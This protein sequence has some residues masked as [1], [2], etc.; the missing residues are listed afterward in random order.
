[1]R[2]KKH[3]NHHHPVPFLLAGK[4]TALGRCFTRPLTSYIG[5]RRVSL[6]YKPLNISPSPFTLILLVSVTVNVVRAAHWI[7]WSC[8]DPPNSTPIPTTSTGSLLAVPGAVKTMGQITGG[9]SVDSIRFIFARA[10]K[11]LGQESPPM[12]VYDEASAATTCSTEIFGK[13]SH[14]RTVSSRGS[15][16][17]DWYGWIPRFDLRDEPI[18]SVHC[19]GNLMTGNCPD[20]PGVGGSTRPA[21]I[22]GRL[23]TTWN[24]RSDIRGSTRRLTDELDNDNSEMDSVL[25]GLSMVNTDEGTASNDTRMAPTRHNALLSPRRK[26]VETGESIEVETRDRRR[27]PSK[28]PAEPQD[29]NAKEQ[30]LA[31]STPEYSEWRDGPCRQRDAMSTMSVCAPLDKV[32][33]DNVRHRVTHSRHRHLYYPVESGARLMFYQTHISS[34]LTKYISFPPSV[35]VRISAL[36][37]FNRTNSGAMAHGIGELEETKN[38]SSVVHLPH[39]PFAMTTHNMAVNSPKLQTLNSKPLMMPP[40]PID[41]PHHDVTRRNPGHEQPRD[42]GDD[43]AHSSLLSSAHGPFLFSFFFLFSPPSPGSFQLGGFH[44]T[45]NATPAVEK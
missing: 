6:F 41:T 30:S 45:S 24:I 13:I 19:L 25:A 9:S 36:A 37:S 40:F 4:I 16:R 11:R 10:T 5:V 32:H 38:K 44:Q 20:G 12:R 42:G 14:G 18:L 31:L 15:R 2:I 3:K 17:K 28:L 33:H 22:L 23:P 43:N 35:V 1:M 27:Q 21:G 39:D 29:Y 8:Q 34:R 7:T 26:G